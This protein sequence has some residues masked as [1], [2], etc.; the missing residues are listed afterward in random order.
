MLAAES[1]TLDRVTTV[2][3]YAAPLDSPVIVQRVASPVAEHVAPPGFAVAVYPDS[4]PLPTLSGAVQA[5]ATRSWPGVAVTAVG[6][7]GD[8]K[9]TAWA[10]SSLG[11]ESPT[12]D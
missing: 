2:T 1:P 7:S 8:A 9:G 10:D 6:A 4:V 5:T 11:A 12:V 3:V